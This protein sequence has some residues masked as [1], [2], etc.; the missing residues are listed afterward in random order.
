MS[1]TRSRERR[2]ILEQLAREPRAFVEETTP[3][4]LLQTTD[5]GLV[6]AFRT[7]GHR[8][9]REPQNRTIGT[10]IGVRP[11]ELSSPNRMQLVVQQGTA[12][13]VFFVDIGEPVIIRRP[14]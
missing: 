11:P 2:R 7:A 9:S 1:R 10:L 8:L 13:A 12:E 14:S 4:R 3:A 6:V 5:I